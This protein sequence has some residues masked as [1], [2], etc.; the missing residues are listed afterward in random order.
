MFVGELD[1]SGLPLHNFFDY[2]VLI[3]FVFIVVIVI[4]NLLTSV[5]IMEVQEIRNVSSDRAWEMLA[6]KM[7]FWEL[8]LIRLESCFG[9]CFRTVLGRY[10]R[11]LYAFNSDKKILCYPNQRTGRMERKRHGKIVI[12]EGE[13]EAD[14]KKVR[15]GLEGLKSFHQNF[16]FKRR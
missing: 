8:T 4:M 7:N 6:M 9:K 10:Q 16:V 3:I 12:V 1:H 14:A 5:A 13:I 2:L 11:S 15:P